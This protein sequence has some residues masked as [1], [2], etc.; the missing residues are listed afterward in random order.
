MKDDHEPLKRHPNLVPLSREH[1][2]VLILAQLLKKDVPDYKGLPQTIEGKIVYTLGYFKQELLPH[3][4]KEEQLIITKVK[5]YSSELD[6]LCNTIC[7]EHRVISLAIEELRDIDEAIASE[8]LD[9][10]GRLLEAHVRREE[11][12]WFQM[13]QEKVPEKVLEKIL[14]DA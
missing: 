11:R 8:H 4:E 6:K 2:Q 9:A 14:V 12:M 13:I 1:H 10:L 3:F 7:E 5:G